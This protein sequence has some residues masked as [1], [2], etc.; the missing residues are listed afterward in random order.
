MIA[1]LRVVEDAFVRMHPALLENFFRERTVAREIAQRAERLLHR[2]DVILRQR[3][4]VRS[5]VGQHLVLFVERLRESERVLCA[6]TETS[7]RLTLQGGEVV[8]QRRHLRRG[9]AFLSDDAGLAQAFRANGFRSRLVPKSL[10]LLLNVALLGVRP[11]KLFVEPLARITPALRCERPQHL[12]IIPRHEL[13]NLRLTIHHDGQRRRLHPAHRRLVEAAR[14]RV[15]G[16][17]GARAID[18][19]EPVGFRARTRRVRERQHGFVAAEL[20]KTFANRVRGHGLEPEPLHRLSRA[21]EGHDV[22]ENQLALAAGVASVDHGI[23]V[24]P[25]EQLLQNFQPAGAALDGLQPEVGRQV[26]QVREGPLALLDLKFVGDNQLEQMPDGGRDHGVLALEEL[27]AGVLF[28]PA[29]RLGDVRGDGRF[30]G[31]DE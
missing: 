28:E 31:N 24:L 11:L 12:P 7:V 15:E 13:P 10:G 4:R 20:L 18:A 27:L 30:F 1:D 25:L 22:A 14:L 17:H 23:H 9:L 6:E 8:K 5:R 21:R 3:A 26:R 19:H 16:R 2:G 29:E